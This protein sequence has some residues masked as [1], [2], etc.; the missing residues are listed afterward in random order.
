MTPA[1]IE[2]RQALG[3]Y[4]VGA[5][6][7][8]ERAFVDRHLVGCAECRDELAGLA[9]LPALLG[10][11]TLDEVERGSVDDYAGHPPERL[12]TAMLEKARRRRAQRRRNVVLAVAASAVVLLGAGAGAEAL[13]TGPAGTHAPVA[14]GPHWETVSHTDAATN[15]SAEVKY[16]GRAW[17]TETNV[18]VSGIPFG[19]KCDLWAKDAS[20]R[21]TLV[22]SWKYESERAWYPGS[23]AIDAPSITSFVV[24][25]HGKNLVT[26][27]AT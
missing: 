19:T 4:V 6:D 17:G 9:G 11:V 8:S 27:P 26:I 23:A 21:R 22:G 12:L 1:C 18:W 13:V 7:P 25:A 10:R 2:T 5:I 20:G 3:V 24:T 15:V 16:L 14:Q